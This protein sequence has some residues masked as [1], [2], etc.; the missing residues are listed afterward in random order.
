LGTTVVD[1]CWQIGLETE[2][3]KDI[4]EGVVEVS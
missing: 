1:R 4:D 3:S 2:A